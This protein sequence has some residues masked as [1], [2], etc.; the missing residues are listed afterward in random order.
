VVPTARRDVPV[1]SLADYL[2]P[3]PVRTAED[4][5]G[6]L[7][8]AARAQGE[9]G[10][11]R[12]PKETVARLQTRLDGLAERLAAEDLG[13]LVDLR[14]TLPATIRLGDFLRTRVVELIVHGDDVAASIALN[15]DPPN[16]AAAVAINTLLAVAINTHGHLEGLRALA[17]RE[18]STG[19]VLP[20]L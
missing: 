15:L 12:G 5:D 8:V 16:D 7:H 1:W 19:G 10:G 17:R 13:R 11:Q 4:L 6:P 20:V 2:A 9:R 3:F 14:P 18:R